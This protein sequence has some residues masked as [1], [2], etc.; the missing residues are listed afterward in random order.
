M[1][2]VGQPITNG[3]NQPYGFTICDYNSGFTGIRIAGNGSSG[4]CSIGLNGQVFIDQLLTLEGG[5][6]CNTGNI[7]TP[8]NAVLGNIFSDII[9]NYDQ[10]TGTDI[11]LNPNN[12]VTC[13]VNAGNSSILPTAPIGYGGLKIGYNCSNL[14]GETDFINLANYTLTGGFNFYTM[15]ASNLPSLIGS[16]TPSSLIISGTLT[17]NSIVNSSATQPYIIQ[18]GTMPLPTTTSTL[19]GLGIGWNAINGGGFGET[20]FINY[21]QAGGGGGFNF[22]TIT[23]TQTNRNIATLGLYGNY[24]LWLYSNAGRLRIDDRNGGSFWWSQSQEGSQMLMSNNGISTSITLGCGNA[25]GVGSTC[26]SINTSSVSPNVNLN[27]LST[28]TFNVSHPTTSLALP[29]LSNQYATVGYVSSVVSPNLLPLNNTWTGTNLYRNS[30]GGIT[31]SLTATLINNYFGCGAGNAQ[32]VVMGGNSLGT[33]NALNTLNIAICPTPNACLQNNIG[34]NNIAIGN[35]SGN[36]QTSANRNIYIG[37]QCG[38]SS[39]GSNNICIGGSSGV[40]ITSGSNN[41]AIGNNSWTGA[42]TFSNCA[43]I[44]A[45]APAP[46]SSNSI[47]L[48]STAETVYVQ[49]ASQ[50]SNTLLIG[51][52]VASNNFQVNQMI[53]QPVLTFTAGLQTFTTIPPYI[54]YTPA[55]GLGFVYPAPSTANAGCRF[56]IRRVAVGGSQTINFSCTG[57]PAVWVAL[58]QTAGVTSINIASLSPW[59]SEWFSSG[60]LFYQ[61]I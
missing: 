43:V 33:V 50:L 15:N 10:N 35:A 25:S 14:T 61:L 40:G 42:N 12:F 53:L 54:L 51:T 6:F 48:G 55:V 9:N 20:D 60:S 11:S 49:G 23:S 18:T 57:S 1:L 4:N 41:I 22:S 39:T 34:N 31:T 16:L 8:N 38:T 36:A 30:T 2:Y 29:T 26:L 44:G 13:L 52:T 47:I 24:G 21:G 58:N 59:Q 45:S 7:T 28:T 17:N 32:N 3:I 5:L 19:S 46:L 56:V 27:P 37:T